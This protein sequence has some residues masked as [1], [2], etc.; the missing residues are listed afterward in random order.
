MSAVPLQGFFEGLPSGSVPWSAWIMPLFWW[1]CPDR[2]AD[3]CAAVYGG[4]AEKAMGRKRASNLSPDFS[5]VR[6]G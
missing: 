2:G 4:D 5:C 3:F 6:S 1:M